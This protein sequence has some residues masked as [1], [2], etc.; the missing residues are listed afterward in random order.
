LDA[1]VVGCDA[2]DAGPDWVRLRVPGAAVRSIPWSSITAAAAPADDPN[3]TFKGDMSPMTEYRATHT[4]LWIEYGDGVA[5]AM[6]ERDDPRREA[7][8]STFRERLGGKWIEGLNTQQAAMRLF[9]A[10]PTVTRME[11][12]IKWMVLIIAAMLVL[13]ILAFVAFQLMRSK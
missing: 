12:R 2:I 13:P 10:M 1:V 8:L 5:V 6:L 11:S 4:P 7:I 9:Q 3:M